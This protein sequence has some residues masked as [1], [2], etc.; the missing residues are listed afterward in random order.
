VAEMNRTA[1]HP[2]TVVKNK[3]S[4]RIK[5]IDETHADFLFTKAVQRLLDVN[6][7][8]HYSGKMSCRF[9]LT[10]NAGIHINQFAEE[11]N[12]I[13]I[14][15]PGIHAKPGKGYEWVTID[16]IAYHEREAG[17]ML[18]LLKVKPPRK[19]SKNWGKTTLFFNTHASSTFVITRLNLEITC[20]VIRKNEKSEKPPIGFFQKI[21]AFFKTLI[22]RLL[23]SKL[24]WKLLTRGVLCYSNK[25]KDLVK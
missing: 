25:E 5:C 22:T 23:L 17:E 16:R 3:T 11:G 14:D 12:I 24:Q 8:Q 13:R 18:F 2:Y 1:S 19:P 21:R 15:I 20:S 9:H 10:D 7:W 6:N 4:S